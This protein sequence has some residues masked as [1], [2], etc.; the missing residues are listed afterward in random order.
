M[1]NTANRTELL[2]RGNQTIPP[3]PRAS[4]STKGVIATET[5]PRAKSGRHGEAV[6]FGV[7]SRDGEMMGVQA[8][9]HIHEGRRERRCVRAAREVEGRGGAAQALNI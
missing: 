8:R 2:R 3:R 9:L 7:Q 4:L 1:Y 5:E 6:A